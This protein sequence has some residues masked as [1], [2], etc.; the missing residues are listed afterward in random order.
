MLSRLVF[1]FVSSIAAAAV[2]PSPFSDLFFEPNLG[3]SPRET[4]YLA[5][6][7]GARL[8]FEP[9]GLRIESHGGVVRLRFAGAQ[10][11]ARFEPLDRSPDRSAYMV[12]RDES[13]WTRD[14]P[15]YRRLA[16]RGVYPGIDA[17]FYGSGGRIEYD[18]VVAPGAD[19]GRI[20]VCFEGA[21]LSIAG[22]GELTARAGAL[23]IA[24]LRPRV[25]QRSR[26][27]GERP[28]VARYRL[29]GGHE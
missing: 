5:R 19:T 16:W 22:S 21:T 25:Y 3:Q 8:S 10:P 27:G 24:M 14:V 29:H 17:I 9:D 23:D 28:I 2:A 15:H 7:G 1:L 18:L 11:A 6:T 13:K 4:Q 12:G 26:D 20:R